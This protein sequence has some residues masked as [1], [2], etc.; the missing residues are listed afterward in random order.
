MEWKVTF[1]EVR[2]IM[3][4]T[5]SK[6]LNAIINQLKHDKGNHNITPRSPSLWNL[7]ASQTEQELNERLLLGVP[8]QGYA[9]QRQRQLA[10]IQVTQA[11]ISTLTSLPKSAAS[12][13]APSL[14]PE[15]LILPKKQ[16]IQLDMQAR[17]DALVISEAG[18]AP[19]PPKKK[20]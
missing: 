9:A 10:L 19:I 2:H 11:P 8:L 15:K 3:L 14:R 5:L 6:N 12:N 18:G 4:T 16:Q 13:R 20:K 7:V 1:P 17:L